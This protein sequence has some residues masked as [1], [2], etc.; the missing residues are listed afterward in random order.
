MHRGLVSAC[1]LVAAFAGCAP[2]PTAT[3]PMAS[4]TPT[5]TPV[6][7]VSPTGQPARLPTEAFSDISEE[8]VSEERAA[9]FQATLDDMAAGA[10]MSAT[11]MTAEG[12]W[13]GAAGKADGVRDV[14]AED[15]FAIASVTKSIVAAQVM[16]LIEAGEL[17]LDDPAAGYLPPDLDFDT[18]GATIRQLLGH[19]SG[20]PDY[21]PALFNPATQESPSSDRRRV[22]TPAEMLD[23]VTADRRPAGA[24]FAYTN[25]NY[26]LLGLVI[27]K[28]RARPVADVLRDGVLTVAGAERLIYQPD[29]APSE[30]VAMPFGMSTANL[31]EGGGYL[32]SL[33]GVTG[34][35]PA[36]GMASDSVSLARWWRAFCAGEVVSQASLTEMTTFRDGFGL[37]LYGPYAGA[38]GHTGAHIGYA[39]WAGCFAGDG[40][41]LVVLTNQAVDDIGAMAGPLVRA[42]RSR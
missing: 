16:Q 36:A 31:E 2:T 24:S 6:A 41:V 33:A 26:L 13:S 11:V 8:P 19:R 18:N 9:E 21:D 38:V 14:V 12:T 3:D 4:V 15:Q 27:E 34:D 40:A 1:A 5:T 37:G 17:E 25:V 23:L 20:L 32:P 30:P 22:W 39:S 28:V 7:A 35:S 29:E 10:G 42:L